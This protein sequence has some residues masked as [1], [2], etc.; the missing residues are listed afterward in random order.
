VNGY[1]KMMFCWVMHRPRKL[2]DGSQ[3]LNQDQFVPLEALMLYIPVWWGMLH[4]FWAFYL[5]QKSL[6]QGFAFSGGTRLRILSFMR[7][8][9][10][11]ESLFWLLAMGVTFIAYASHQRDDCLNHPCIQV[12]ENASCSI[13]GIMSVYGNNH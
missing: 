3:W 5:A 12:Y 6:Q 10:T 13:L 2:F 4:S 9:I 7:R 8:F 11:G 1:S